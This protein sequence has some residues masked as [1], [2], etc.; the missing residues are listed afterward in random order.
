MFFSGGNN[1]FTDIKEGVLTLGVGSDLSDTT[2]VSIDSGAVFDVD[3]SDVVGSISGV[4]DIH[5]ESGATLSA[6]AIIPVQVL[7]DNK[8]DELVT[9]TGTLTFKALSHHPCWSYHVEAEIS[10]TVPMVF[11]MV[12]LLLPAAR[13]LISIYLMYWVQSMAP[14]RYSLLGVNLSVGQ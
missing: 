7:A 8:R 2:S 10:I 4:G 13:S 14:A 6:G 11:P 5:L 3:V 9:G 1:G 12:Q